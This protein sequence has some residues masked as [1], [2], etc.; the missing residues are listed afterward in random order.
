MKKSHTNKKPV[1]FMLCCGSKNCPIVTQL[2]DSSK[3]TIADD[4]GGKVTLTQSQLIEL[5][6]KLKEHGLDNIS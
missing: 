6:N 5:T 2:D 3:F 4:Y 1:E